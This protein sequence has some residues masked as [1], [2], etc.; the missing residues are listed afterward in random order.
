MGLKESHI[1][2]SSIHPEGGRGESTMQLNI[3][4]GGLISEQNRPD[5]YFRRH[6]LMGLLSV[7][8]AGRCYPGDSVMT[9]D[10]TTKVIT[11]RIAQSPGRLWLS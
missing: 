1:R 7:M 9:H 3:M 6:V 2:S 10:I 5:S 11:L 4:I 8:L